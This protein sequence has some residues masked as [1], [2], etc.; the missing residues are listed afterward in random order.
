MEK[1]I[2]YLEHLR[3]LTPELFKF[4]FLTVLIACERTTG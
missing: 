3:H 4:E 1:A 2:D